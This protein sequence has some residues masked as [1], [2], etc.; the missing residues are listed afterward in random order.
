LLPISQGGAPSN[1]QQ[2][3]TPVFEILEHPADI[4]FR[5][6]GRSLAELFEHAAVALVSIAGEPADVE[7][8]Q[9]YELD[10]AGSDYESR[11]L[12]YSN[13]VVRQGDGYDGW[14]GQAPFDR[15]IVTAA[16]PEIPKALIEQLKPGGRLAAP[17]GSGP[18]QQLVVLDKKPDGSLLHSFG[19]MVTF[20]PM[21]SVHK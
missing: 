21:R 11:D 1:G 3:N 15:I 5:A 7:A 9:C 12:G 8:R 19:P 13:V 14:S 16:P 2:V 4:G 20:V 10:A 17:I 18:M 6:F